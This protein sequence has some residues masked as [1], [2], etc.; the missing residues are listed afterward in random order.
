MPSFLRAVR[1]CRPAAALACLVLLAPCAAAFTPRQTPARFDARAIAPPDRVAGVAAVPAATLAAGDPLRAGW[2]R[3]ALESEGGWSAW[4]DE[5]SGLP[6]LAIGRGIEWFPVDAAGRPAGEPPGLEQLESLARAFVERNP[7]VLGRVGG[8]LEL[9][10]AASGP[11]GDRV[12]LVSFRQVVDGVPVDGARYDFQLVGGRFVALGA[13]RWSE[14]RAETA[15]RLAREAARAALDAYLGIGSPDEVVELEPGLLHLLPIAAGGDRARAWA[16]ARGAGWTHR[17]T[18]RFVL[19]VP[20]EPPTW[21]AE[22]DAATGEIVAL[23]DDTRYARAKGGIFPLSND[24]IGPEGTEQPGFPMPFADAGTTQTA[25]DQGV[26][27]CSSGTI[28]STLAGP[29]IRVSDKCG[30]VSSS[31]SCP[32]DI[33][34]GSGPGTDCAVPPGGSPGNTHA[35]RSSFYHLNRVMEKGRAWLP[36]NGWLASQVVDNVNINNT[37]NAFWNGSVN[38]YRSGGGCRNTGELQGVFVH[39]WGHGLDAN[40]GGGYDNPSEAYADIVAFLEARESCVGRG[41]FVGGNCSGY[42]DPCLDCSGIRDQDWGKHQRQLPATPTNFLQT[43]CGGGDGPCGREGHCEAYVSAQAVWDLAARDLPAAGMDPASAWQLTEKLFYLSRAGSGGSAYNCALPASDGCGAGSWFHKFRLQDDND[44]NLTNGTPH[45]AAIYAAFARHGIACG[46]PTD[47]SNQNASTCPPMARP[48][49]SGSPNGADVRLSWNVVAGTSRY[50]VLRNDLGCGR[51]QTIVADVASPT[52]SYTD[53]AVAAGR[54]LYYR[55]LAQASNSACESAV[56]DCVAVTTAAPAGRVELDRDRYACGALL[57]VNVLDGNAPATV[58]AR[59]WSASEPQPEIL[60]LAQT[61]P[62]SGQ[63]GGSLVT[64]AGPAVAGDGLLSIATGDTITAEYTDADDGEG[65]TGIARRAD[66]AGDCA[67]PAISAVAATAIT[68]REATITWQTDEASDGLVTWGPRV[69]PQST[70]AAATLTTAH[71]VTLSGLEPC[72][73]YRFSVRSTDPAGNAAV[74]D[75]GGAYHRF[76]TLGNFGGGLE[77]CR[78]GTVTID[79]AA[80]RC[81]TP[82]SFAVVDVDLNRDPGAVETA[83]VSV[84]S[85]TEVMPETVIV[86][87]D[88]ADSPR[89]AGAIALAPGSPAPDG[90]LQAGHGDALTVSYADADDGHGGAAWRTTTARADCR[91]PAITGLVVDALTNARATVRFTTDEPGDTVVRWGTTPALGQVA[92]VP[93]AVTAHAVTLN[94]FDSCQPVYLRVE[95]ADA[96]GNVAVADAGG[97]P[98]AFRTWTI[99]GLYWRETFEGAASGWT[100]QGEWEI[101][102]PQG[103]GGASF[104]VPDPAAPYNNAKIMGHDLSGRGAAPGDYE[105]GSSEKATSPTL[106]ASAWR[107][108]EL[109]VHRQLNAGP[110]D[111]ASI[112]LCAGSCGAVYRSALQ[113]VSDAD[114]TVQRY[115]VSADADGRSSLRLEFRQNSILGTGSGWNVDDV[116]FKDA[117]TPDYAA[118]GGCAQAPAFA[119]AAAARDDNACSASGVTV[120][121]EPA[122]AWGSGAPG[123]YAVYRG[124]APGFPADAAHRIAS[125]LK[126]LSYADATAPAGALYYLVRAEND[127]TCGGGPANGGVTDANAVYAPV[128]QTTSRPLPSAVLP[129]AAVLANHAHVRLAWPAAAGATGYRVYRSLTPQAGGFSLLATT[130]GLVYEDLDQQ[131]DPATRFYLV[132]GVNPCGQEGP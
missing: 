80:P 77:T 97:A 32:R 3:L 2:D 1:A 128:E 66:A 19:A 22:I 113:A 36:D 50:R 109:I 118:C 58:T 101:G 4:I 26:F 75:A 86:T 102:A 81:G 37:C 12:F 30:A 82:L 48:A 51:G 115:D 61:G 62:G 129:L 41:F 71:A 39:E 127:E 53:T 23:Y 29:Y 10:R 123:S 35:A 125:G 44:G 114:Y 132:R 107:R 73:V 25:N 100:L 60:T 70:A 5:R 38:F 110:G 96:A 122:V 17:L 78:T 8:Q 116:I 52:T 14:V 64:T 108:T 34:F 42:G 76:L 45:A 99:P 68:D 56:S 105:A 124:P 20:D 85:T 16:G 47:P 88:G 7:V 57:R 83:V 94:Q 55:V 28:V 74:D 72:T 18:W 6:T 63:Y 92:S 13:A 49:L 40:D 95:S 104:G 120:S 117:A 130:S 89:F 54:T 98:H 119:G 46:A 111:D 93:G 9:D 15:P 65:G 126:T 91:G 31:A 103:R 43:N 106:N 131:Q 21:V 79:Q 33:D 90:R 121:W 59:V 11:A 67:A 112:Y 84:A 69:P 27:S 24:G 87:E